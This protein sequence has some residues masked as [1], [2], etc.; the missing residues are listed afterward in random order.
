VSFGRMAFPST[1]CS[2]LRW[3]RVR[4]CCTLNK[5]QDVRPLEGSGTGKKRSSR[6]TIRDGQKA[7]ASEG[8]RYK[9][10][11]TFHIREKREERFGLQIG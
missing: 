10:E 2:K 6:R 9:R 11:P 1:R 7:L 3:L 5:S 8:G 4:G